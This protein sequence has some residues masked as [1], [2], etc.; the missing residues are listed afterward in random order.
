MDWARRAQLCR[1]ATDVR[2]KFLSML[3]CIF[4]FRMAPAQIM[5]KPLCTVKNGKNEREQSGRAYQ[6]G[7]RKTHSKRP[8]R[9]C[10]KE[11]ESWQKCA[12]DHDHETT[13]RKAKPQIDPPW[14]SF[15]LILLLTLIPRALHVK[16]HPLQD[17]HSAG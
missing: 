10:K 17:S 16:R 8:R 2:T 4:F 13:T 11:G 5:A 14:C 3:F 6:W 1:G 15:E 9:L 12:M 7:E